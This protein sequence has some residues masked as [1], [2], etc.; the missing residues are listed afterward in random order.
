[1]VNR[2]GLT[3]GLLLFTKIFLVTFKYTS[4]ICY[5]LILSFAKRLLNLLCCKSCNNFT[6][7]RQR[8]FYFNTSPFF[9]KRCTSLLYINGVVL[10]QLSY[11]IL[12]RNRSRTCAWSC[13]SNQ[14][15][16]P[17]LPGEG[18]EPST[19]NLVAG[20]KYSSNSIQIVITS[21]LLCFKTLT[22]FAF[23]RC[24]PVLPLSKLLN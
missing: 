22:W 23:C 9:K 6:N 17:V 19:H 2:F 16:Y 18:V 14:L 4:A 12:S 8:N 15:S 3:V 21:A 1:M 7:S 13:C 11:P 5:L 10:Y 20:I 24:I